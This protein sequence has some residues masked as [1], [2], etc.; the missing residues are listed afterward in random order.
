MRKLTLRG[1][2]AAAGRERAA[3]E[4]I[5]EARR[6]RLGALSPEPYQTASIVR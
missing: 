6:R 2:G 3:V 5:L 1:L 4:A